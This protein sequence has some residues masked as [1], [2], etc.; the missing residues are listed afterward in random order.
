MET[1][2]RVS[3]FSQLLEARH[4]LRQ[5]IALETALMEHISE[6]PE[7]DFCQNAREA[8]ALGA[9]YAYLHRG[10][11][12]TEHVFSAFFALQPKNKYLDPDV[13]RSEQEIIIKA[14][15]D[16]SDTEEFPVI[17]PAIDHYKVQ[18]LAAFIVGF[19]V[20]RDFFESIGNVIEMAEPA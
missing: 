1:V 17:D 20:T 6:L 10:A 16:G 18:E 13:V 15:L 19:V 11:D 3:R 4:E 8:V 12:S 2:T 5:H 14:V 9:G 7:E